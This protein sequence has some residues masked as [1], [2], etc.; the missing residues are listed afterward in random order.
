MFKLSILLTLLLTLLLTHVS[1]THYC[2]GNLNSDKTHCGELKAKVIDSLTFF[3]YVNVH[4]VLTKTKHVFIV[5]PTT[6]LNNKTV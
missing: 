3:K 6:S 1:S 2:S 5:Y 4:Q